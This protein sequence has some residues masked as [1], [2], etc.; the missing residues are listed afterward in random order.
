[1]NIDLWA[2]HLLALQAHSVPLLGA[3]YCARHAIGSTDH[4][5]ASSPVDILSKGGSPEVAYTYNGSNLS[6]V[7][8]SR[9]AL[10]KIKSLA[11]PSFA[12]AFKKMVKKFPE[13]VDITKDAKYQAFRDG[14][15]QVLADFKNYYA[16]LIAVMEFTETSAAV[17]QQSTNLVNLSFDINPEL[18]NAFLDVL[19]AHVSVV[20]LAASIG[21]EKKI[22][23]SAYAKAYQLAN[24][25]TE[26]NFLRLGKHLMA[27]DKPL[28]AIHE[29]CSM[30]A[31]K[32][33][34]LL[35]EMK[36]DLDARLCMTA[37]NFRK[38]AILSLTPEMSGI[39]AP[40]PDEKHLRGLTIMNRQFRILIVGFLACP[41]EITKQSGYLDLLKQ[42]LQYGQ[43]V[44]LHRNEMLNI[45]GE[46]EGAFKSQKKLASLKNYVSDVI[47]TTW[48]SCPALHRDRREYLRH[49]IKQM[50]CLS[51]DRGI[52]CAK[53][54]KVASALGFAR[55]EVLWYFYHLDLD[56]GGKKRTK[57]DVRNLDVGV[58]ELI[59]LIKDLSKSL[60]K[61]IDVV[62]DH[63][64]QQ[65][66]QFYA[67]NLLNLIENALGPDIETESI[68]ILLKE[69]HRLVTMF[70]T[71]DINELIDEGGL[72]ALRMNWLRFQLAAALPSSGG[73]AN[74]S[75]ISWMM[76][77]LCERSKWL[78]RYNE[79]LDELCSLRE[80]C[81][82]QSVLHEHLRECIET[83]PELVR[84]CGAF[85]SIAEEF[86]SNVSAAWPQ[87][88]KH[89]AVHSVL[90]ATEVYSILGQL[91][92]GVAHDIAIISV[93]HGN[94][95]LTQESIPAH[96][97]ATGSDKSKKSKK[98]YVE[99]ALPNPG[100][101]SVLSGTDSGVRNMERLKQLMRNLLFALTGP[102]TTVIYDSEF[103][104]F[105]FFLESIG[106][107]FASHLLASVYK[108]PEA[109][110]A[111]G[112]LGFASTTEEAFSFD[113]KRPS[114]Y[115]TEVKGYLTAMRF[116]DC[117]VPLSCTSAIREVLLEKVSFTSAREYA[118]A[119]PDQMVY[120]VAKDQK[121]PHRSNKPGAIS[122]NQPILAVYMAWY[123]EFLG[124]R[125][126]TG[127]ICFSL[128]RRAFLSRTH[129]IFQAETYTDLNELCALCELVG[130]QG[131]RF[132]D[133][134]LAKMI[135]S[136]GNT[137]KDLMTST[138]GLLEG[139]RA[140]W[141]DETKSWEA[142]KKFRHMKDF[143]GRMINLGFI[144][145]FRNLLNHAVRLVFKD[146][147]PHIYTSIETAHTHYAPN[148]TAQ[149]PYK[150]V[151][152]MA[153]DIGITGIVDMRIRAVVATLIGGV[154][155]AGLWSQ[156]PY[157]A[158]AMLFNLAYDDS[159]TYN[160]YIDGLE[161]NGHCLSSAFRVLLAGL[162]PPAG[163]P[164]TWSAEKEFLNV[165]STILMRLV[166][167]A[168]D[169]ELHAK[170]LESSFLVL[171][172]FVEDSSVISADIAE[173]IIPYAIFQLVTG[174]V[175]RKRVDLHHKRSPG[176]TTALNAAE[177]DAAF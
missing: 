83:A 78:D 81:F 137:L 157:L 36:P 88:A 21:Q 10:E 122:T 77:D 175:Y 164:E 23:A 2:D 9:P 118:D 103:Q 44:P 135:G 3:L 133:E 55:D 75:D 116:L 168:H 26:P 38:M 167:K 144:I 56:A 85:G 124:S 24:G 126:T 91:A 99:K 158:A 106:E 51:S 48:A 117:M 90:F 11:D 1:M 148:L 41:A 64:A 113:V 22:I 107:R 129:L 19:V 120:Q 28:A 32:I 52:I 8:P 17:L 65:I 169:K 20:Y 131:V 98:N 125:A 16:L 163:A 147:C 30:L 72:Q 108:P 53:F 159:A 61:N 142:L 58:I 161:N 76:T 87:E 140:Q 40:E 143:T 174:A 156:L 84:Y 18:V 114:V 101:E 127:T 139:L 68:G 149:R 172:R 165:S 152:S 111:T 162:A 102:V 35:M 71:D 151:D 119:Q 89:I 96:Q 146:K 60:K 79:T 39:K 14:H 57:K 13:P 171:K 34:S 145:D 12:D 132:I 4:S 176:S 82:Y 25:P 70:T 86:L 66:G 33:V 27:Y 37:D 128:N 47:T 31:P 50:I 95:L 59:W 69:L 46:F 67:P 105:E 94:Q 154:S 121:R 80:L 138:L 115:L 45:T 160:A 29:T 134:Q 109:P 170:N 97:K 74:I 173:S 92:G 155:D 5:I 42:T 62:R 49:Q 7:S 177:D 100:S 54:P 6:P 123:L 104:P 15:L 112:L 141:A 150:V 43:A 130:P 110:V 73:I 136:L 63:F 153:N 166:Q 93:S